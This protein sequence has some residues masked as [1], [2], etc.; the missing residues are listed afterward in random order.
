ML[1]SRFRTLDLFPKTTEDVRIRT[2]TGGILSLASSAIIVILSFSSF[3][4]YR[5]VIVH[6]EIFVDQSRS[7][8]IDIN[9][10]VTL[11]KAPCARMVLHFHPLVKRLTL[12]VLSLDVMDVSGDQQQDV[13]H[14]L[15]KTRLD[16]KGRAIKAGLINELG[17]TETSDSDYC[18]PCYGGFTPESGCCNS[19]EDVR[20]G[21]RRKGWAIEDVDA[22]EQCV[23]EHYKDKMLEEAKEGCRISGVI[24]VNK[25]QGNFHI[26]PGHIELTD[27]IHIHDVQSF[28]M[29]SSQHD[30]SHTINHLSFGLQPPEAQKNPLDGK[31][32]KSNNPAYTFIY[33]IKSVSTRYEYLSSPALETNQFSV[34]SHSRPLVGG[35][36]EEDPSHIHARGGIPGLFF[37][38]EISPIRVINKEV[39]NGT[40]GGF[41]GEVVAIIG[42][43][44]TIA[45]MLDRWLYGQ[46][47]RAEVKKSV[48]KES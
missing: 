5:R 26:A 29:D 28:F 31:A 24:T 17:N 13:S 44:I 19:C 14:R 23:R 46:S 34:T 35:K 20:T 33:F 10:D 38:Y 37:Q 40:F 22:I 3:I 47:R 9:L 4:N 42:G 36:D 7:D 6:P 18:G 48:G 45:T 30:F 8:K 32:V 41:L 1:R 43:V 21:Y 25:V 2:N 15:H 16:D 27:T 11:P 39:R 12:I